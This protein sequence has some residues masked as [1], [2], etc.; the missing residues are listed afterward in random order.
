MIKSM[1]KVMGLTATLSTLILSMSAYAVP[2][3]G[4]N[5]G[6][7]STITNP[8]SFNCTIKN[9]KDSDKV[10]LAN[11][12]VMI[13]GF[14]K[15][16]KLTT[17]VKTINSFYFKSYHDPKYPNEDGLVIVTVRNPQADVSCQLGAAPGRTLMPGGYGSP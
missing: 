16:G 2:V 12:A 4:L 1:V 8:Q 11:R 13:T 17:D 9:A 14:N 5:L 10:D 15:H 6:Q 7:T 3:T